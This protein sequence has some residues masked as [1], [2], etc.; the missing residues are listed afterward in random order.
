MKTLTLFL[1]A[2]TSAIACSCGSFGSFS[3]KLPNRADQKVAVFTAKVL[4]F[5]EGRAPTSPPVAIENRDSDN[6]QSAMR[7]NSIGDAKTPLAP[8][9]KLQDRRVVFQ[10][11]EVFSGPVKGSVDA[12]TPQQSSACGLDFIVGE[13]YLVEA[14]FW[15]PEKPVW[16][17]NLCSRTKPLRD[18]QATENLRTLRQWQ[19]GE[20]PPGRVT[21][22]VWVQKERRNIAGVRIQLTNSERTLTTHTGANG[23]FTFENVPPGLYEAV[24]DLPVNNRRTVDLREAWY[25]SWVVFSVGEP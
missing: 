16:S 7:A 21:G 13:T 17:V 18:S 12:F 23:L 20:R 6:R 25:V 8:F 22:E 19:K 3:E 1:L 4:R 5:D 9:P 10:T 11:L 24:A 2:S 14:R 15:P